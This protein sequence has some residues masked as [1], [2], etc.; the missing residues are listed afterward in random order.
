[1]CMRKPP[2]PKKT[3]SKNKPVDYTRYSAN[4]QQLVLRDMAT[5]IEYGQV[6]MDR[7][8]QVKMPGLV[9]QKL[10]T[11][12]PELDRSAV[13]TKLAIQAILDKERFADLDDVVFF[14]PTEQADLD[15]LWNYLEEREQK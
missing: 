8:I 9:L 12:F 2:K 5:T 3:T 10:D 1:M 11:L 13:I 6:T 15:T 4:Q 7:R 14:T